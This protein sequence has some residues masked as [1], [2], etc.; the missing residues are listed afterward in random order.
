MRIALFSC[1]VVTIISFVQLEEQK[2][3]ICCSLFCGKQ[4]YHLPKQTRYD[5]Y[6]YQHF[7]QDCEEYHVG[8]R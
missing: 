7:C 2:H 8:E 6:Q 5:L 3:T 1:I 4:L